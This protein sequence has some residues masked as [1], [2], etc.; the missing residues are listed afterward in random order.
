M[1]ALHDTRGMEDILLSVLTED[2]TA[3]GHPVVPDANGDR[4]LVA[5]KSRWE[6]IHTALAD[7][8][9]FPRFWSDALSRGGLFLEDEAQIAAV[10]AALHGGTEEETDEAEEAPTPAPF[11]AG[12]ASAEGSGDYQLLVVPHGLVADGRGGDSPWLLGSARAHLEDHVAALD[13]GL[14]GNGRSL[15]IDLERSRKT[16][17]CR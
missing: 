5:L 8:S 9:A 15:G 10:E 11:T 14:A 12:D 1:R 2:G 4:F 7:G 13:R 6:G 17:A 3:R 16:R